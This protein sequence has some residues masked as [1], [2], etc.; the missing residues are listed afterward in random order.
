MSHVTQMNEC[1]FCNEIADIIL[2]DA[3][4]P[5]LLEINLSP[6]LR[7]TT[8]VKAAMSHALVDDMVHLLI[9]QRTTQFTI[10]CSNYRGVGLI[11]GELPL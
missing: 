9:S 5:W 7:G 3:L 2:D 11:C 1:P 4:H 6:D 10:V 8:P